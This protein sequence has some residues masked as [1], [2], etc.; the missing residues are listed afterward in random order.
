[1]IAEAMACGRAVIASR[2]GGAVEIVTADVDAMTHPPGDVDAL[3]SAIRALVVDP[4]RR[5]ELGRA[6]RTTAQR[7]FDRSRLA[8][9][10]RPV[11]DSVLQHAAL[12]A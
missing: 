4:G 9:E 2:G 3:A 12:G 8:R 6:A 11:Y 1:V 5:A 7:A 10:L